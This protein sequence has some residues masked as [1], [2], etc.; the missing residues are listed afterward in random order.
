M[1]L[2]QKVSD[3]LAFKKKNKKNH[4]SCKNKHRSTEDSRGLDIDSS[5][6]LAVNLATV[7]FLTIQQVQL[8]PGHPMDEKLRSLAYFA[9][10]F[11]D[12]WCQTNIFCGKTPQYI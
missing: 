9:V 2:I 5:H 6:D 11:P 4:A 12:F 8:A 1:Y 3:F 7:A 10:H